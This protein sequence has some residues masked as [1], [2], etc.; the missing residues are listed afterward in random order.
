MAASKTRLKTHHSFIV[1]YNITQS[2]ASYPKPEK[3][4]VFVWKQRLN[5]CRSINGAA[6]L[7]Q[8]NV[9]AAHR[10]L[11]QNS[12]KNQ[13]TL[14]WSCLNMLDPCMKVIIYKFVPHTKQAKNIWNARSTRIA[15]FVGPQVLFL[16]YK[17]NIYFFCNWDTVYSI[18]LLEKA[19]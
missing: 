17:G 15:I 16:E 6:A 19:M 18:I 5:P 13:K 2:F 8:E 1:L 3:L 9:A 7:F 4:L 10:S 14:L 11:L 12:K